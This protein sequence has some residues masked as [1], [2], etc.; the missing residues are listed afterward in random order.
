MIHRCFDP[1]DAFMWR[2][3]PSVRPVARPE[4]DLEEMDGALGT[5]DTCVL[6]NLGSK[7]LRSQFH[8]GANCREHPGRNHESHVPRVRA[9]AN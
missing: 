1:C 5:R 7:L 3:E 8:S 4:R 2:S 9:E 6:L